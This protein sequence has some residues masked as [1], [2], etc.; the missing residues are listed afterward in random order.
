MEER[1]RDGFL[2]SDDD[3][4]VRRVWE[5]EVAINGGNWELG[6]FSKSESSAEMRR[7]KSEGRRVGK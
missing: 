6:G 2:R 3:D 5:A 4:G 1:E 7:K